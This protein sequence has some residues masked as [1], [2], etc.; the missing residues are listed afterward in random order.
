MSSNYIRTVKSRLMRDF[1]I[2]FRGFTL[3]KLICNCAKM[4]FQ[5]GCIQKWNL[6]KS[7]CDDGVKIE[8]RLVLANDGG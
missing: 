3:K 7:G 5:R 8:L 2:F 6:Q 1:G 4:C